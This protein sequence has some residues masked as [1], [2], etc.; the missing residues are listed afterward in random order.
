MEGFH[1]YTSTKS[2]QGHRSQTWRSLRS[3]N[4]SCFFYISMCVCV[5]FFFCFV[6]YLVCVF[7]HVC[8]WMY[9]FVDGWVGVYCIF[10]FFFC[11]CDGCMM[12][13]WCVCVCVICACLY[14]CVYECVCVC[15]CIWM[16]VYAIWIA[17][18]CVLSVCPV[19]CL[20]VHF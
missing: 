14:A 4:A 17:R 5:I 12:Y 20:Y 18:N 16:R 3:L 8:V 11:K 9:V 19:V 2:C 10:L 1:H 13:V 7:R 6:F 15:E